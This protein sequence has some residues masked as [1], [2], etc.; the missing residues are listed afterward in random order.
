MDS[1]LRG[2][3]LD[4]PV[5]WARRHG[6]E[7]VDYA[8]LRGPKITPRKWL[9]AVAA[10][11]GRTHRDGAALVDAILRRAGLS[12]YA[13][14]TISTLTPYARAV[15]AVAESAVTI[16]GKPDRKVVVP[17]PPLPWPQRHELRRVAAELLA[18]SNVVLHAREAGELAPL[19]PREAIENGSGTSL[20]A[21]TGK[22]A[23]LVRVYGTGEPYETFRA[24]VEALGVTIAGGPIAHVLTA[25]AGVGPREVLGA[26]YD[27]G[28][29][30]LEVR[31]AMV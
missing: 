20:A 7:V 4:D 10:I 6:V 12:A 9:E 19:L 2:L 24:A 11:D 13:N 29:D 17:E 5:A 3:V 21:A 27:A 8:A 26:A 31:E 30:V 1:A 28:L 25:P 15:L 23:I 16:S 14:V 22:R 18:G